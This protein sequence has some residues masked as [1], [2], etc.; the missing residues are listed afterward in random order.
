MCD[1]SCEQRPL[2]LFCLPIP[3]ET[4]LSHPLSLFLYFP[5]SLMPREDV[6]KILAQEEGGGKD[7]KNE[8]RHG[9]ETKN[10]VVL[11]EAKSDVNNFKTHIEATYTGKKKTDQE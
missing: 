10:G 11:R 9:S 8:K 4:S 6:I 1:V 3:P 7:A 2:S 5:L